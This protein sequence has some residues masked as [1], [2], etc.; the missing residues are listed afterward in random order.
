M[1]DAIDALAERVG[2]L[3]VTLGAEGSVVA[4]GAERR[5]VP[6]FPVEAVDTTGAGDTYCGV[7]AAQLPVERTR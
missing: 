6:A 4:L 3:V 1:S 7:L 2:A 5:Q